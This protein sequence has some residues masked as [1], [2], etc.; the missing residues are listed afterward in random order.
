MK[1]WKAF[2]S[3]S[4]CSILPYI[5]SIIKKRKGKVKSGNVVASS[6]AHAREKRCWCVL[7]LESIYLIF[8]VHV[9]HEEV[10][11]SASILEKK[12]PYW[13]IVLFTRVSEHGLHFVSQE[14]S[15]P[16]VWFPSPCP[17]C[18]YIQPPAS[19]R[20]S[21]QPILWRG[22]LNDLHSGLGLISEHQRYPWTLCVANS[23][24]QSK[25]ISW[26]RF[27]L[28]LVKAWD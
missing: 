19:E 14:I 24:R 5:L 18:G 3:D 28:S 20:F 8:V 11:K 12:L 7:F 27:A 6:F 9:K 1:D 2:V 17:H 4:V 26:G 15:S 22:G 21:H 10:L 13:K 23:A 25:W 16:S